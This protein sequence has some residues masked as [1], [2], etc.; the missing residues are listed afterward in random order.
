MTYVHLVV[1]VHL[2]VDIK[3]LWKVVIE[4]VLLKKE[5]NYEYSS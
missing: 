5:E 4:R 2:I 1:C 3:I